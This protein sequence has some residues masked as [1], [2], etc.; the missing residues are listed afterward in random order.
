MSGGPPDTGPENGGNPTDPTGPPEPSATVASETLY[1][2]L[3]GY[4]FARRYVGGKV[5][6]NIGR[7]SLGYGSRLLSQAAE[8]VVGLTDSAE[9]AGVVSR[10]HPAPNVEYGEMEF[11]TVPYPDGHFDVVVALEEPGPPERLVDEARRVLKPD[12]VLILSTLDRRAL[13]DAG[14]A[15]EGRRQGMYVSEFRALLGRHF[16]RVR[17][18]RRGAVAGGFVFP[19]A[20]EITGASVESTPSSATLPPVGP[21]PPA[22]RWVLAVCSPADTPD[23]ESLAEQEGPYLLLDRD[24][25]VFDEGEDLAEAV[26]LLRSEIERMQRTEAQAFRDSYRLL[27]SEIAF[28]RAQVRR[29]ESHARRIEGMRIESGRTESGS[30]AEY[31]ARI[32]ALQDRIRAIESSAT[33]RVFEPYRRLRTRLDAAVKG[34]R[35]K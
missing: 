1:D 30:E 31:M 5:V 14:P 20:G 6:A 11:P 4:G 9:V 21:E 7:N 24:R 13:L 16:G 12:G 15:G 34:T 2:G 27:F 32:Q 18:F 3:A 10:S 35:D 26:D 29:S 25:R 8:Q 19:E 33:W 23:G 17:V 22:T 28:L